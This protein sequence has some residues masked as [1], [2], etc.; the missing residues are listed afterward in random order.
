MTDLAGPATPLMRHTPA[1]LLVYQFLGATFER[2]EHGAG[3]PLAVTF[4]LPMV[5]SSP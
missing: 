1:H 2:V 3:R 4:E 5:A